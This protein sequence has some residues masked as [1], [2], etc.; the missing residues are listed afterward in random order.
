[1]RAAEITSG[2]VQSAC[3]H[4]QT[5]YRAISQAVSRHLRQAYLIGY[6]SQRADTGHGFAAWSTGLILKDLKA[7]LPV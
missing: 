2:C 7:F 6:T 5:V 4:T 3:P 1:M